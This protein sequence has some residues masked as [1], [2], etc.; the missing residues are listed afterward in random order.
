MWWPASPP[1]AS[2]VSATSWAAPAIWKACVRAAARTATQLRLRE[3]IELHMDRLGS[4]FASWDSDGNGRISMLEF[5]R[6]LPELGVE[7]ATEEDADVL[8]RQLDRDGSGQISAN[9]LR[10]HFGSLTAEQELAVDAFFQSLDTD[11]DGTVSRAEFASF[12]NRM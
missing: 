2:P 11:G 4:L 1:S 5:R 6:A 7:G 8:F 9:E 12:W 10:A 3:A